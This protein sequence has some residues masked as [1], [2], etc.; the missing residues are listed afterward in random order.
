M[1]AARLW[2]LG[3]TIPAWLIVVAFLISTVST[4]GDAL[5]AYGEAFGLGLGMS[6][7]QVLSLGTELEES[8][9]S[10][11]WGPRYR[12][13]KLPRPFGDE[14]WVWLY[15]GNNNRLFRI[16][17]ELADGGAAYDSKNALRRYKEIKDNLSSRYA[18]VTSR[19]Q[20]IPEGEPCFN[21]P[22][23]T[24]AGGEAL[25]AKAREAYEIA[26]DSGGHHSLISMMHFCTI[27]NWTA[28]YD[29]SDTYVT[30]TLSPK[31]ARPETSWAFI[32]IKVESKSLAED[33]RRARSAPLAGRRES[34]KTRSA[35]TPK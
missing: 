29:K 4:V 5:A 23:L 32:H 7:E 33:F 24:H 17:A 35:T 22:T 2:S 8:G 26:L 21:P 34:R 14:R 15:F 30:L 10:E 27:K 12:V 16:V 18:K 9:I 19:E 25:E 31:D 20:L 6:Q 13:K 1:R 11:T 3:K 28:E